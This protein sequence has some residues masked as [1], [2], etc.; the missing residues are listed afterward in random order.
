ME[1]Q[2]VIDLQVTYRLRIAFCEV[3]YKEYESVDG[4]VVDS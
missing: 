3:S 2:N 1:I 4:G